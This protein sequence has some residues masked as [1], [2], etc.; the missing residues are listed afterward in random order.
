MC[1]ESVAP[2]ARGGA[3]LCTSSHYYGV[4]CSSFIINGL[5]R[6]SHVLLC[7]YATNRLMLGK[8][9]KTLIIMR[10][11]MGHNEMIQVGMLPPDPKKKLIHTASVSYSWRLYFTRSFL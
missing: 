5:P 1:S 8:R 7:G 10:V 4:S 3:H 6:L 11:V 9:C 2:G